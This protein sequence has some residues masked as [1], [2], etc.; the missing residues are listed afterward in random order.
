[1]T[2]LNHRGGPICLKT[3]TVIGKA[4]SVLVVGPSSSVAIRGGLALL[5]MAVVLVKQSVSPRR[6][7]CR[8]QGAAT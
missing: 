7:E 6:L 2:P 4:I 5:I 8:V 3:L 1:M